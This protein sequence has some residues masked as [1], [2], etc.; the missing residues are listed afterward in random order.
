MNC[1]QML[2]HNLVLYQRYDQSGSGAIKVR[3]SHFWSQSHFSSIYSFTE[4]EIEIKIETVSLLWPW[5]QIN[6]TRN[7]FVR[8]FVLYLNLYK[9]S[10]KWI[11]W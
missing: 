10:F 2:R 4:S 6:T 3:Q 9:L 8:Q 1:D 5:S 7:T 11:D